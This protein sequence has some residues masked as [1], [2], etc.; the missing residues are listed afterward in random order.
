MKFGK[1][2]TFRIA[3]KDKENNDQPKH[4]S[5]KGYKVLGLEPKYPSMIVHRYYD[6]HGNEQ[7]YLN[8]WAISEYNTG[9]TLIPSSIRHYDNSTRQKVIESVLQYLN[10]LP[11]ETLQNIKT[12]FDGKY[13]KIN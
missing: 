6:S 4:L 5:I 7:D 9:Y 11:T 8:C 2:R 1:R 10:E 12:Q 13:P 3:I